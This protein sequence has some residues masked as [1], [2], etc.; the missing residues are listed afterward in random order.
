MQWLGKAPYVRF[1]EI[2]ELE[3][4]ISSE[5]FKII[6]TG[7]YPPPSRYIVARKVV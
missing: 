1:M 3:H 7:N 4:I 2:A 6:E 5:G